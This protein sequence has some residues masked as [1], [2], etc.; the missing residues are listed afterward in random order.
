M[1]IIRPHFFR[2][3][4]GRTALDSLYGAVRFNANVLFQNSSSKSTTGLGLELLPTPA[5][6]TRTSIVPKASNT[7]RTTCAGATTSTRSA[8]IANE[9]APQTGESCYD[10]IAD[11]TADSESVCLPSH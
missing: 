2:S 1:F 6:L 8:R 3:M 10:G 4:M 7:C 11:M 9:A 5:L